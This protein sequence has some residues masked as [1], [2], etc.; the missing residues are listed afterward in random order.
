MLPG[1]NSATASGGTP[2]AEATSAADRADQIVAA[3]RIAQNGSVAHLSRKN[4]AFRARARA[5]RAERDRATPADS[6]HAC[7]RKL[8]FVR[9]DVVAGL[10][11]DVFHAAGDKKVA[12]RKVG[13]IA[14]VDPR[15][16]SFR[17]LPRGKRF[18][19]AA[20]LL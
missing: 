19:V 6:L 3:A 1:G 20:G 18:S 8:H 9:I 13:A 14:G 12:F 4:Q 16:R 11:D 10:D 17:R 5:F 15:V 2:I 7:G